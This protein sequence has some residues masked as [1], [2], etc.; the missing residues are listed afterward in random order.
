MFFL[1]NQPFSTP[2]CQRY[3]L[4]KYPVASLQTQRRKPLQQGNNMHHALPTAAAN[5]TQQHKH[6]S[7]TYLAKGHPRSPMPTVQAHERPQG[8]GSPWCIQPHAGLWLHE[9]S[10]GV[11]ADTG[12]PA[13]C[14]PHIMWCC[15]Q[16][17]T[18]LYCHDLA[19]LICYVVRRYTSLDNLV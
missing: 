5:Y 17:S 9:H 13:C 11:A 3:V 14:C 16:Q 7:T 15:S 8:L 6:D 12:W 10:K 4:A 19:H 2:S 18:R 1:Q